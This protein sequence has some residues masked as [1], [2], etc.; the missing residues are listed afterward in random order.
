VQDIVLT[1]VCPHSLGV[2]VVKQHTPGHMEQGF[3]EPIIDRNSPVPI[4]RSKL[5]STLHPEQ[6]EI[7]IQ[8][9]QGESRKVEDNQKIG[10]LRVKG[11]KLPMGKPNSGAIDVRFTY[12]M[13]SL[14][15]VEVTHLA[16][17]KKTAKVFEQRPG[18][19]TESQIVEAIARLAPL[20]QHPRDTPHHRALLE[21]ANRL[22]AELV[23]ELRQSLN[24]FIDSFEA[25]L[26]TQDKERISQTAEDLETFMRPFFASEGGTDAP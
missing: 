14:L 20:K 25:A 1:D 22:F 9:Y 3:F 21:R 16:T 4:S 11:L 23:G 8:V 5:L 2:M 7:Q 13:N 17:N 19:L 6:D 15:E 24:H 12:D 10:D 18:Q 26:N